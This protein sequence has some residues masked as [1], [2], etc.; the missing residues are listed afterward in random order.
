MREAAAFEEARAGAVWA[1]LLTEP[2]AD[3]GEAARAAAVA[4][5]AG[6]APFAVLD[7]DAVGGC[8]G[9]GP[10]SVSALAL[11]ADSRCVVGGASDGVCTAW[12]VSL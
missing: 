8:G 10:A 4:A 3:S 12:R 2:W 9:S 6:T 5:R 7:A 1:A 11:S